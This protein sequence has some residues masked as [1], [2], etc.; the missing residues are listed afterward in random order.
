MKVRRI[1]HK[2]LL[3]IL[4]YSPR[5][6]QFTW[7]TTIGKRA[8]EGDVAGTLMN[9]GYR[10]IIIERQH[11]LEHV[12]AWFYMHGVWPKNQIDHK[13]R[14]KHDNRKSNLRPATNQENQQNVCRARRNNAT[15]L[16]GVSLHKSLGKYSAQIYVDAKKRHL[17]YFE[18]PDEAHQAYLK[19]KSELHKFTGY[20]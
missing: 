6:G 7:K 3:E 2:R 5:T 8:Q 20:N 11:Y 13:N 14:V 4:H 18:K 19:A 10:K 1:S 16:L 15:G 17:G 12:L 9:K